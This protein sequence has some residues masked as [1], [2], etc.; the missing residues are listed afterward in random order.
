MSTIAN[1]K[2]T[3]PGGPGR[4][5]ARLVGSGGR[6]AAVWVAL[7]LMIPLSRLF[8]ASFPSSA[9]IENL[10]TLGLFLTIIALGQGLVVLTGG[11][12]LSVAVSVSL[13]AFFT[14]YTASSGLPTPIA[15]ALGLA[16]AALVGLINGLIVAFTTF[17][18]FIVTLAVSSVFTALLLGFSQGRPGQTAPKS[19]VGLF[20]PRLLGVPLSTVMLLVVTALGFWIQHRTSF[21]R[22]VYAVG[23]S[24]RAARIAGLPV[25]LTVAVVYVLAAAAYGLAGVLLMGYNSGSDLN[26]GASWLLPS[27]AAVVVGGSAI[28][29]GSGNFL[30]TVGA[31]LFLTLIGIDISAAGLSEGVKQVLYGGVLLIALLLNRLGGAR[32]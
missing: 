10:I 23:G 9:L 17:P 18:P 2:D 5:R 7:L 12:D 28:R 19:L 15:V 25:R 20:G 29:G 32:S 4:V 24:L 8:S 14:G 22:R 3:A 21:G 6:A 31:A 1:M 27:I 13:A 11:I 16:A 26:L 30:G